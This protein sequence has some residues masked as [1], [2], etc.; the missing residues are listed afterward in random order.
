MPADM[1][2]GR[3][4]QD[5][6]PIAGREMAFH[7]GLRAA[8]RADHDTVDRLFGALGLDDARA[9]G[10]FLTAH[11]LALLPI[12]RWLRDAPAGMASRMIALKPRG[13]A[14]G[15]D[16]AALGLPVREGT[17]LAWSHDPA[18]LWGVAYV[19]EGSRLGG[20]MLARQV[21]AGLPRAYL[22]SVHGPG[23]WRNFL[24]AMEREAAGATS[25]WRERAIQSAGMA[26]AT[27]AE[28]AR[29]VGE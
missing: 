26:F 14:L 10:R 19:T 12:E 21:P 15:A 25:A 16:L 18:G 20:A 11:A 2:S 5:G 4:G 23:G 29:S 3:S 13:A 8:T 24:N 9:Y 7:A 22:N 17:P 27:F 1:A 6:A 28:A